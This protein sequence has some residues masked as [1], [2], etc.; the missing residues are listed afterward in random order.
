MIFPTRE[1]ETGLFGEKP[2]TK[3]IFPFSR[4]K[5]R[6]WQG[7]ENRGSLISVPLALRVFGFPWFFAFMFFR[8]FP[9]SFPGIL[10]FG[11]VGKSLFSWW[12][13]LRFLEK[14]NKDRTIRDVP[15]FDRLLAHGPDDVGIRTVEFNKPTAWGAVVSKPSGQ[16]MPNSAELTKPVTMT[17]FWQFALAVMFEWKCNGL[18]IS[19]ASANVAS[20]KKLFGCALGNTNLHLEPSPRVSYFA[21]ADWDGSSLYMNGRAVTLDSFFTGVVDVTPRS[22]AVMPGKLDIDVDGLLFFFRDLLQANRVFQSF[23]SNVGGRL[24]MA[25]LCSAVEWTNGGFC[26]FGSAGTGLGG[27][28]AMQIHDRCLAISLD[29]G[30]HHQIKNFVRVL[31]PR[32]SSG[33]LVGECR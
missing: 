18:K 28:Y 6:I 1:R 11:R 9:P 14:K 32:V 30:R 4:G 16:R 29:L 10:G 23:A 17:P 21:A 13:S 25:T 26:C 8:P 24:D 3:A 7:V 33:S 12:V 31:G 27:G 19:A 15:R 22:E 20:L 5:N 2:S